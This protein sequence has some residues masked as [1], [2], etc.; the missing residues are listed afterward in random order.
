[1]FLLP[2]LR[3]VKPAVVASLKTQ[4][5]RD[6]K[7]FWCRYFWRWFFAASVAGVTNLNVALSNFCCLHIRIWL[8]PFYGHCEQNAMREEGLFMS[9][10]IHY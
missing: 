5:V 1:M 9:L 3:A 10:V 7:L 4:A 8:R 2:I 6:L